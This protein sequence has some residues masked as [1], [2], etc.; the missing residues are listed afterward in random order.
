MDRRSRSPTSPAADRGDAA[1]SGIPH[2]RTPMACI[3]C[4]RKKT[5]CSGHYPSCRNCLRVGKPCEWPSLHD[6]QHEP[7]LRQ[8]GAESG[9]GHDPGITASYPTLGTA[10]DNFIEQPVAKKMVE[11]FFDHPSFAVVSQCLHR[12]SLEASLGS[13]SQSFLLYAIGSLVSVADSSRKGL[14][15]SGVG[16]LETL[17]SRLAAVARCLSRD[18]SDAPSLPAVQANTILAYREL[19]C[20]R[21]VKAWM[22]AG[23]AIRMAQLL[24]LHREYHNRT[25]ALEQEVRR[26]MM[27]TCY[28][29]DRLMAVAC[30]RPQTVLR[31]SLTIQLPAPEDDFLFGVKF[32]GPKLDNFSAQS[33]VQC[34]FSYFIK[35]VDLW[36][37]STTQFPLGKLFNDDTQ[38]MNPLPPPNEAASLWLKSLPAPLTWSTQNYALHRKRGTATLFATNV[39]V[40]NH[41]VCIG[42]QDYLLLSS[43]GHSNASSTMWVEIQEHIAPT[44]FVCADE[45]RSIAAHLH[46]EETDGRETLKTPFSGMAL[47]TAATIF[48]WQIYCSEDSPGSPGS[49][50][51]LLLEQKVLEIHKILDTWASDWR[52]ARA[53]RESIELV[54]QVYATAYQKPVI[55]FPPP[56]NDLEQ[57]SDDAPEGEES[58][59]LGGGIPDPDNNSISL[60][61]SVR[62]LFVTLSESPETRREQAQKYVRAMWREVFS[63]GASTLWDPASDLQDMLDL[64]LINLSGGPYEFQYGT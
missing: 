49:E 17:S 35:A 44:C 50:I 10:S 14:Q 5:K 23:T 6:Q 3:A 16:N 47:L 53:W 52:L 55:E 25:T 15:H 39:L 43:S 8:A 29:L 34:L 45:I 27:W 41:A 60:V 12:P 19:M 59:S 61:R 57:Y 18:S 48:L 24:R 22:Y 4:R 38:A 56:S 36:A 30:S 9:A 21:A 64:P 20:S 58:L 32:V 33:S 7:A 13:G 28:I 37:E 42:L 46:S 54:T 63:R 26:R 51:I 11:I 31:D 1:R 40:L 62:G 2:R